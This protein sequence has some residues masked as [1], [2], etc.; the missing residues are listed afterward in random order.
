MKILWNH[1]R[2]EAV[3]QQIIDTRVFLVTPNA[4]IIFSKTYNIAAMN[5]FIVHKYKI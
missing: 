5:K 3:T 2:G 1:A 4:D